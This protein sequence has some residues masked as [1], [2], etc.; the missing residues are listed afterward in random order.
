MHRAQQTCL[1]D[2][3]VLLHSTFFLATLI[4]GCSTAAMDSGGED[5]LGPSGNSAKSASSSDVHCWPPPL[6]FPSFDKTCSADTDCEVALNQIDCCGTQRSIGINRSEDVRFSA[7]EQICEDQYPPCGCA[8]RGIDT[9]DG[10]TVRYR[11]DVGLACVD[12]ACLT[13]ALD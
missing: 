10:N 8:G 12:G 5:R 6:V 9:E 13:F 2:H 4:V 1:N 11:D 3:H 7:A